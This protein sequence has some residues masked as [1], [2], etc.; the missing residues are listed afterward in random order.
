[1]GWIV[2]YFAI[3]LGLIVISGLLVKDSRKRI[4][5]GCLIVLAMFLLP[6]LACYGIPY[7]EIFASQIRWR[8]YGSLTYDI[9]IKHIDHEFSRFWFNGTL[10]VRD[11][12]V[13]GC[14]DAP[15]QKG[16]LDQD[17]PDGF[18]LNPQY[19]RQY[20]VDGLFDTAMKCRAELPFPCQIEF[21]PHY[22]Y[23]RQI[24][25]GFV[26]ITEISVTFFRSNP[27]TA[28]FELPPKIQ[29]EDR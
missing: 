8:I 20:T 6:P 18:T 13:I 23:P 26:D 7:L 28:I 19:F 5:C 15:E 27:Q 29:L 1:M 2:A 12:K 24:L 9:A 16:T 17:C 10:S 11:G 22:G 4:R 25:D 21:D 3:I 14:R